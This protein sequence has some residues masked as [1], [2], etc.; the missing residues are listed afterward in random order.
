MHSL[1]ND[2]D[3]RALVDRLSARF[4][5]DVALRVYTSRLLGQDPTLVL[6]GGGNTSVKGTAREI[7][8]ED[9]PVLYVKGSGWDLAT[10]EPEGFPACRLG[11]LL[12]CLSLETL[13]DE[14]MVKA[15]RSQ[16]LDPSSPTPSVEALLH[17]FI[18]GR[19][20]DHTHANAVLALVDQPDGMDRA[21]DVWGDAL[22]IVPYVMPGFVLARQIAGLGKAVHE[23]Q[24]LVL[25]RHGIFTWGETARESYERMIEAVSAAEAY[26]SKARARAAVPATGA[27]PDAADARRRLRRWLTPVLRGALARAEGGGRFVVTWRDD[28]AIEQLLQRPDGPEIA[29]VGTITPDHVLRTKPIPMWLGDLPDPEIDHHALH[30]R[31]EAE[32]GRYREWYAAYFDENAERSPV[33]LTRLDP[34]PRVFLV[35]GAGAACIGKT[36]GDAAIVGDLYAHTAQVILAATAIGKYQPVSHADLFDVEYW[37]LEQAKLKVLATPGGPLARRIALV[38]G[39]ARGIGLA[40]AEH[41]LSLGAH[42]FLSDADPETLEKAAKAL[43][44]KYSGRVAHGACDVTIAERCHRLVGDV[45]ERFG[46]LDLVVSNAGNAPSGLLHT[47]IGEGELERSLRLNLMGHQHV[48]HAACHVF[49]AQDIGGCLLFNASKSAFNPGKEFGPYAVPKAALV[50]LMRQYAVDLGGNGIRSN[51][52]NADRIRTALFDGIIEAR[53]KARGVSPDEYFKDNLLRRETTAEDVARAFGHLATAE[54]T[55]GSVL[56]VDGGN[57]A[58]FP[59]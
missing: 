13:S 52:V 1:W 19:F 44:K 36:A 33:P 12:R 23:K 55:T 7:T 41:F 16:M 15:L 43:A 57:A 29:R 48:A 42:V 31:V 18:P 2:A 27:R 59:R 24:L 14:G 38:T 47:E 20:V 6:H 26:V 28:P 53:A 40:T 25:N 9:V 50:A 11:P 45:V 8:G 39:A 46:G 17:A 49:L 51:A 54:A 35:P 3:A 37:S 22:I 32:L 56:T 30:T 5:E 10:I 34:L 58:A 4:G 21:R